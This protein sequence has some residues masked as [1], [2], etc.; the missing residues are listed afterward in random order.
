MSEANA[1]IPVLATRDEIPFA[2]IVRA[3]SGVS[4]VPEKRAEDTQ[5]SYVAEIEELYAAFLPLATTD[6]LR[7]KLLAHVL[8]YK[9]RYRR[10]VLAMLAAKSRVVS[11]IIAGPSGFPAR[12]MQ[13][14][15]N[16]EHKRLDELLDF[17]ERARIAIRRDLVGPSS[18]SSDLED[19]P[20]LLAVRRDRLVAHHE[21]M[22]E[23][24]KAWRIKDAAKRVAALE[25]LGYSESDI[26]FIC[27]RTIQPHPKWQLTNSSANI[28]RIEQRIFQ[29]AADRATQR[30]MADAVVSFAATDAHPAGRL[31]VEDNR[32]CLA[33][34]ERT[35][36]D[37][38]RSLRGRGF[39][40]SPSREAFVRKYTA[41]ALSWGKQLVGLK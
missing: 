30:A 15:A 40:W 32:V 10:H 38:Y 25:A 3:Y 2:T 23:T 8:A 13:K 17:R 36:K 35:S 29:I 7:A 12:T 22:V 19:A 14:R 5:T 27:G 34:E 28:K 31:F 26:P 21:R 18:I 41:D 1:A 16:T 9:A 24:N 11:T 39:L 33:F 20:E 6:E 37:F 4:F